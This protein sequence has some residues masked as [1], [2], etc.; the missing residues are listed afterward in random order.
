[1]KTGFSGRMGSKI[2]APRL[3]KLT[4]VDSHTA[5]KQNKF[6]GGRFSW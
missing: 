6:H 3:L 5:G 4:P 1:T 2:P